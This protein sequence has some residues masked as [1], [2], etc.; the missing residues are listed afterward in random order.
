M[1][2][3]NKSILM[4][5]ILTCAILLNACSNTTKTSQSAS[6]GS[7]SGKN[8]SEYIS[9]TLLSSL[10]FS[11]ISDISDSSN[12]SDTSDVSNSSHLSDSSHESGMNESSSIAG[13]DSSNQSSSSA[14]QTAKPT[15]FFKGEKPAVLSNPY[16][17]PTKA[18]ITIKGKSYYV[19][20]EDGNDNNTGSLGNP[21][22]T[23]SKAASIMVAGDACYIR[24]GIYRETITPAN[25]G[26]TNA[27]I[28]FSSYANEKVVVSGADIIT[29]FSS[30]SGSIYQADMNFSM[31]LGKDQVFVDGEAVVQARYP[32]KDIRSNSFAV[33]SGLFPTRGY[34]TID[35]NSPSRISSPYLIQTGV[36]Y[37]KD[38]IYIGGHNAAWAWQS[39]VISTS[40]QGQLSVT[41]KT[42]NWWF[43]LV[44][45]Y[46][47]EMSEGYI[48]N[49]LN[50]LDI[51]G[52]WHCQ[53]NKLY[54]WMPKSDKP[55][56]HT[57][58]AKRRMLAF[59]LRSKNNIYLFGIDIFAA[60]VTMAKSVNCVL[61]KSLASYTSHYLLFD[62]ARDGFIDN[63]AKSEENSPMSGQVGIYVSGRNNKIINSTIQYSAGAGI[64]LAGYGTVVENNIVHD[65]GY[66]G[67]YVGGIFADDEFNNQGNKTDVK[68]GNYSIRYNTVY[69]T[70]RAA[71]TFGSINSNLAFYAGSD[72][73]YNQIFN[74][75]LFTSD[76]GSLYSYF[77]NFSA[78]GKRTQLHHN[79]FWNE[80]RR[81][82]E[83]VIYFDN[84]CEGI[85]AHDNVMWSH[86][87]S[88][89]SILQMKT[90]S[91]NKNNLPKDTGNNKYLGIVEALP[92]QLPNSAYAGGKGYFTG[93]MHLNSP[94]VA[95][96]PV[97]PRVKPYTAPTGEVPRTGW[98]ASASSY[99]DETTMPG[100]AIDNNVKYTWWAIEGTAQAPGDWFMIDMGKVNTFSR[101]VMKSEMNNSPRSYDILVSKDG[102][103]W[104]DPIGMGDSC[105][106]IVDVKLFS[107]QSARFV[108][109]NQNEK[110][111][112]IWGQYWMIQD[113]RFYEK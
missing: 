37:W 3:K 98:K 44:D 19:S 15:D 81:S 74:T 80:F 49:S 54:I 52:E 34:F 60:S 36:N 69:N 68:L 6:D 33:Y 104:S 22:K 85:D 102:V 42:K 103:N 65:T 94:G 100:Y 9:G 11:D 77:V 93:A 28:L 13:N 1:S 109:I 105:T 5:T 24:E 20:Q 39:A 99:R 27:S 57:V 88:D 97:L 113:I 63:A 26:N 96:V 72:I 67:T 8:S 18:P 73:S 71:L 58:E 90:D 48:T 91:K 17:V 40:K 82:G 50:A 29:G 66:A 101:I 53:N 76:G 21:F 45:F 56:S 84:Q 12:I 14:S 59:D 61:D 23:I 10:P 47:A 87:Y 110:T 64:Y 79:L 32:N 108:K 46:S 106:N 86:Q 95:G 89:K 16:T 7:G 51:A 25:S 70:S 83:G 107:P 30:Y 43:P 62:D 111:N 41:S 55:A 38:G 4:T 31:G 75:M 2:K 35:S 112:P 92:G 78:D